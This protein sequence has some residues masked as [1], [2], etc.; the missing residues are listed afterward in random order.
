[1]LISCYQA[2]EG[3]YIE[4][5]YRARSGAS[6]PKFCRLTED[7]SC[8]V[9]RRIRTPIHSKLTPSARFILRLHR[10]SSHSLVIPSGILLPRSFRAMDSC[11]VGIFNEQT[12]R[13]VRPRFSLVNKRSACRP[14]VLPASQISLTPQ[15]FITFR[16]PSCI[17]A[18]S[19][20]HDELKVPRQGREHGARR[21][22]LAV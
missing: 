22:W 8:R 9:E 15:Q 18:V 10:H 7:D 2:D 11:V 12:R 6:Y 1:M 4:G 14:L 21:W 3:E 16:S 19:L 13:F 5:K 20:P 17:S